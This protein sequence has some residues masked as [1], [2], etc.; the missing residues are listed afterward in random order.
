MKKLFC[1]LAAVLLL[2][3]CSSSNET[4]CEPCPETTTSYVDSYTSA[5][6][7][8]STLSG[9][10]LANAEEDLVAL[11]NDLAT[12]AESQVE[13]YVE[14]E[15][16]VAQLMTVNPDGSVG[17]S[18]IHA[19]RYDPEN[20]T[21]TIVVTHGQNALNINEAGDRGS[22]LIHGKAYYLLHV[23]T[24]NTVTLEYSDE[25]YENGEFNMAYSGK[26][27]QFSE[28]TITLDVMSI[29]STQVAMFN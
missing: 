13:G 2:G 18:T 1:C 26:D 20:D 16:S 15:S 22:L 25:T 21:V 10:S 3:A 19:W 5:S 12:L 4:E 8:K 11:S 23:E 14:P 28:Y 17:F 24:T 29:E 7:T 9:D 6:L 27:N